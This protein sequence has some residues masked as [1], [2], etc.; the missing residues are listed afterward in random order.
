[1]NQ[2]QIL[3]FL[4]F[5]VV[6]TILLLLL[7]AILGNNLVLGNDKLSSSHAAIVSG[8]ILAAIIYILPPAVEKSG[9]K[10]K[11]E[12][13]WPIIFFSANAVVIWIIKRF[14]LITGLGLSSIFWVLIVALVITAAELGVAKT[15]GAMKKKK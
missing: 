13:I 3:N 6:N 9:Q 11:N 2:K 4:I 14:A 7:S 5:W 10:I 8:L 1:M 12:N 15:T